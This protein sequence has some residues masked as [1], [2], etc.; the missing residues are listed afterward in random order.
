[1]DE[2]KA[3]NAQ[4][5]VVVEGPLGGTVRALIAAVQRLGE[6]N[7]K[8]DEENQ[9]LRRLVEGV[10]V[11]VED[12]GGRVTEITAELEEAAGGESETVITAA[13]AP[14]EQLG[15]G[16]GTVTALEVEW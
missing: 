7:L 2:K 16:D 6:E 13:T 1:M 8:L 10:S 15:R 12:E 5:V 14:A 11:T 4:D 3:E 9:T